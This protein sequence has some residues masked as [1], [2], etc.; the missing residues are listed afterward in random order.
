MS[1]IVLFHSCANIKYHA[2]PLSLLSASRFLAREK[3]DI[4]LIDGHGKDYREKIID[5]INGA[6]CLCISSMT[7][8]QIRQGLEISRIVKKK[9]PNTKIIWG[10]WH[11]SI[12]PEQTLKEKSIDIVV[13]GY[14]EKTLLEIVHKLEKNEP[15]TNI[16]GIAFKKGKRIIKNPD[17]ELEDINKFPP[18]P[19]D[20][21]DMNKYIRPD[22]GKRTVGYISSF[23]CPHGCGFC[24]EALV[25][26]RRW[27][28]LNAIKVVND[29]EEMVKRYNI[30]SV[31]FYDS[32][33]FVSEDRVN[34]FCKE[35]LKRRLNIKW[36]KANGCIR[37]LNNYKPE[38]WSLMK[39]SGCTEILVGAE[40]GSQQMLDLI[41]KNII[42][43]DILKFQK[44]CNK[45]DIN[46]AYSFMV[47]LP[48]MGGD[49]NK[50]FEDEFY[51][52]VYTIGKL[53]CNIREK[54]YILL[55]RYTPYPGSPIYDLSVKNGW[56][57]PKRLEEWPNVNLDAVKTPWLTKKQID[58]IDEMKKF[59]IPTLRRRYKI[60]GFERFDL[61]LRMLHKISYVIASFRLKHKFFAFPIEVK[62]INFL[63]KNKEVV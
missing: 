28:A 45:Y 25:Y 26:K 33:F 43:D 51:S 57:T 32:N 46:V 56:K 5:C 13:I 1:K 58:M 22:F 27:N 34:K 30:D 17:R 39:K 63:W 55:N 40:S 7:G 8:D 4:I 54:S 21:V 60:P 62:L 14:G 19:Y 10:G 24:S 15:L 23:G 36:G 37:T 59:I 53:L 16:K 2:I 29:L 42:P 31:R 9:S 50:Q 3:H 20:L 18:I 6:L 11:P 49:Y 44:I 35:L 48:P 38:T 12:M 61:L 52:T 41:G 47:G